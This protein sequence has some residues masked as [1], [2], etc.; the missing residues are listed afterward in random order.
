MTIK[1]IETIS[2]KL[3]LT[4]NLAI[5]HSNNHLIFSTVRELFEWDGNVSQEICSLIDE[6]IFYSYFI[7][8][9]NMY[10]EQIL[11]NDEFGNIQLEKQGLTNGSNLCNTNR[12]EINKRKEK[13]IAFAL[14]SKNNLILSEEEYRFTYE[15]VN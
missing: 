9:K 2:S 14:D 12:I 13:L 1:C 15:T 3:E 7:I 4:P 6:K 8:V 11:R 5:N 10:Y